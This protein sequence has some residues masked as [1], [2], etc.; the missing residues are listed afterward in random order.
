[1]DYKGLPFGKA[2]KK[3]KRKKHH[4]SIL[5]QKD[6]TCFICMALYGDYTYKRTEEHHIFDGPNRSHSEAAG[7]KVQ[8]CK[9]HHTEGPEA[10]HNN[11]DIM[12]Y[13]QSI[14]QQAFEADHT[15]E[16]F[17]KIFGRNF[18]ETKN[19]TKEGR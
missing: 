14:G 2:E 18:K 6:G 19:E 17:V 11:I 16:E 7:L 8:L 15:R 12:R 5:H 10:V 4:K 9:A 3:K 1:M 13:L